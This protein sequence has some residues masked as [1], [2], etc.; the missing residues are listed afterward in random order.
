[1]TKKELKS[2]VKKACTEANMTTGEDK[3][4][5]KELHKHTKSYML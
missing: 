3:K 2:I 5:L 4:F 1:V